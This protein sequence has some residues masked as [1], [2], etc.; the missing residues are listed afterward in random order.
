[1]DVAT[2]YDP[3]LRFLIG[4]ASLV[5][6]LAALKAAAPLVS[7]VLLS[8]LLALSVLPI[9][10]WLT[11]R[12]L[13]RW[14]ALVCVISSVLVVGLGTI[15]LLAASVPGLL[16]RLPVYEA[17]LSEL[18][19][20]LERFLEARG[21]TLDRLLSLDLLS[22]AQIVDFTRRILGWVAGALSTSLIVVLLLIL[23][24]L[25]MAE[26]EKREAE[27]L[28]PQLHLE[29]RWREVSEDITRYLSITGLMGFAAALANLVLLLVL[30]VDFPFVWAVLSFFLSF[31]PNIGIVIALLPPAVLGLLE[32][33]W[34]VAIVVVGGYLII[35]NVVDNV[36]KPRVMK[37]GL[38][39]SALAVILSVV[40]WG[41]ILG[42]AGTILAVP[43]TIVAKQ[44]V[45]ALVRG[46]AR[47]GSVAKKR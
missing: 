10:T 27:G 20:A 23:F 45:G 42:P 18:I 47:A 15:S 12:G 17:A 22:P 14:A 40:F 25:R 38:D 43:L 26:F 44:T 33:G 21:T 5:I 19:V 24:V 39:I 1:M 46:E 4:A 36:V 11:Q 2:R 34:V 9:M 7:L 13:P 29:A 35:N 37:A 31:V 32:S 30:G 28:P 8:A 6:V 3:L 16:N 41:W